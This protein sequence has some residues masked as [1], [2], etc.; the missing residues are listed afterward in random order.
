MDWLKATLKGRLT[1]TYS[2]WPRGWLKVI[3]L[4]RYLGSDL[5]MLMD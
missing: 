5:E 3:D 4:G 1:E 2:D